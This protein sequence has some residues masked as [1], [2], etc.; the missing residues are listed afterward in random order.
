VP[1]CNLQ[2]SSIASIFLPSTQAIIFVELFITSYN[3]VLLSLQ[4]K[5][6]PKIS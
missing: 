3:L 2:G 5:L 6:L 1:F 4:Q